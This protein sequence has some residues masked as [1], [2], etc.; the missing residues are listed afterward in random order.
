VGLFALWALAAALVMLGYRPG[1]PLDLVV[2]VAA[3]LPAVVAIVAF[4]RPPVVRGSAAFA[5]VV[6]LGLGAALLLIPSIGGII[7]RVAQP[8]PQTLLPSFEAVYPWF[9]ALGATSI[10]AGIGVARRSLGSDASRG[11]RLALAAAVAIA[12]CAGAGIPFAAAAV[13][14]EIALRDVPSTSS[15]YGP[16]DGADPIDC[17]AA[18]AAGRTARLDLALAGEVD[19]RSTGTVALAGA[20]SGTD[21]EW[22][23]D[24]AGDLAVGRY[25]AARI[26]QDAWALRPRE[27]WTGVPPATLDDATLDLLAIT[28]AMPPEVLPTSEDHGI[29]VIEGARA[30]HCRVAIDGPAFIAAFPQARWLIGSEAPIQRWRGSV[31][32]WVFTDG[33]VGVLDGFVSGEPGG[34]EPG[35]LRATVRARMT[36]TDRDVP[37]T[38]EPPAP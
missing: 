5:G 1:G 25:G 24:V 2:G 7:G 26:G 15:R 14:N 29:E 19:L 36:A 3:S 20:R 8:G 37:V 9:L 11:R 4:L 33:E 27:A 6:W 21:V 16:T 10:L 17:D 30:R 38:L 34:L 32:Y 31:D 35:A 13:G 12:L 18:F 22:T 28:V 23:A